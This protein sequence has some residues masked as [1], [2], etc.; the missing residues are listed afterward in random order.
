MVQDTTVHGAPVTGG[1]SLPLG[2]VVAMRP[3][4]WV[5][6]ALVFAAPTAAGVLTDGPVLL[7]VVATFVAFSAVAS[8]L[9]LVNDVVDAEADRAHPR[10][11]RRPV[12]AGE[13]TPSQALAV[14]GALLAGGSAL[15][16]L[17]RPLVALLVVAYVAVTL[18]YSW[19]LKHVEVLDLLAIASGFVLR[20]GAGAAAAEVPV[21][22]WFLTVMAFGA[23][24]MA[25]G[26]RSS[27]LH[28]AGPDAG[29]S[30][31][32]LAGYST[33][34][35]HQVQA[36]AVGGALLG[37]AL[38]AFE[39]ARLEGAPTG[40]VLELSVAPFAAALLRYLLIM[41]RGRAEAPEEA[42]FSDRTLA[43][44]GAIWVVLFSIGVGAL[45]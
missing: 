8:G 16:L 18:L 37:Y 35:L 17:V 12:A 41:D 20:A 42:L 13:V 24:A 25:A 11:H 21:S 34:Y 29:L 28:R 10:K 40:W 39:E 3:K 6:N 7:A 23:L 4:Q 14:A 15:A 1:R 22:S 38:W 26:K 9:Y 45:A 33:A 2:V 27:E 43:V 30:R 31:P 44:V 19:R 32:V 5:K 36:I